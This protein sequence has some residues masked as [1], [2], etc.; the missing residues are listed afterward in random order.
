MT[1]QYHFYLTCLRLPSHG[2]AYLNFFLY[3]FPRLFSYWDRSVLSTIYR[4]ISFYAI[5]TIKSGHI[6]LFLFVHPHIW[7]IFFLPPSSSSFQATISQLYFT[8]YLYLRYYQDCFLV[9]YLSRASYKCLT[10]IAYTQ[11]TNDCF[12]KLGK[13]I[14]LKYIKN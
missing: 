7:Y 6:V 8:R 2:N 9:Q 5:R 11:I 3:V 10:D 12:C 1:T 14:S 13:K 4:C